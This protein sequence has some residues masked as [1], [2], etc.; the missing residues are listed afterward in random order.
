[1]I[2]H[3]HRV[4]L[5]ALEIEMRMLDFIL[6]S[7]FEIV[8]APISAKNLEAGELGLVSALPRGPRAE[9]L[10]AKSSRLLPRSETWAEVSGSR[11]LQRA[12]ADDRSTSIRD[13]AQRL[14]TR[15]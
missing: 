15:K 5:A 2:V 6:N 1:M 10:A 13:V 4:A 12:R 7:A 14:R 9:I 3:L 8:G 11:Q